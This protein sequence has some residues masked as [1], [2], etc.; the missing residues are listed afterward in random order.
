MRLA[1]SILM[2]ARV[3]RTPDLTPNLSGKPDLEVDRAR[4]KL[5]HISSHQDPSGSI[6]IE[7]ER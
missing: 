2:R 6:D 1:Y 3:S 4:A 7:V 5:E